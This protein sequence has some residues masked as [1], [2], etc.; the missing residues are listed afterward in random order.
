MTTPR[1]A[2]I[3]FL[4]NKYDISLLV[5]GLGSAITVQAICNLTCIAKVVC[6]NTPN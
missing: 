6:F 2:N 1:D 5:G 4:E 3:D